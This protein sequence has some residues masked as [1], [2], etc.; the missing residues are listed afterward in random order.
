MDSRSE[1]D[2]PHLSVVSSSCSRL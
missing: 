1:D 2:Q